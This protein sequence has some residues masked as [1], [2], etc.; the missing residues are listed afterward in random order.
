MLPSFME[1]PNT[2]AATH[3]RIANDV[4]NR[5]STI[6]SVVIYVISVKIKDVFFVLL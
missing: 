5:D 6:F 4:I 2:T 3:T 1:M